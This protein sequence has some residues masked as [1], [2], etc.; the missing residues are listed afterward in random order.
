MRRIGLAV[1]VATHLL[2]VSLTA[3][4]ARGATSDVPGDDSAHNAT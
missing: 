3:R 4:T 2:V 1:V